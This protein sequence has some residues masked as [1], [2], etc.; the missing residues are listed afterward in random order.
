MADVK[1]ILSSLGLSQDNAG[2]WTATGGWRK[3]AGAKVIESI[4]PAT[5]Q[6]IAK[7]HCATEAD[8]EQLIKDS[9][10][11]FKVWR[12]VPA[13]KRGEAVRLMGEELRKHK[14]ALGSLVSL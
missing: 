12:E 9:E 13:P 5:G 3:S 6:A 10:A 14:D 8:Y 7:V 1:Q 11:A 4:N 2:V